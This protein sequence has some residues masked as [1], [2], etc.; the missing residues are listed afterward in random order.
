MP[1]SFADIDRVP[2]RMSGL[3]APVYYKPPVAPQAMELDSTTAAGMDAKSAAR[4]CT[5]C[6]KAKAKCVRRPG[7]A[8][9][10][11]CVDACA[12]FVEQNAN[13]FKDVLA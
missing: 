3:I 2:L 7:Q 1:I 9:C 5:T 8:I 6:S 13:S 4:S 10:E 11:R 12:C